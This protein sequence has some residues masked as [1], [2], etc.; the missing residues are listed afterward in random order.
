MPIDRWMDKEDMVHIYNGILLSHKKEWN[1]VICRDIDRPRDC[2]TEWSK[3]E[4]EKQISYIN[5][6]IWKLEKQYR[7]TCLQGR[8]KDTD[9]EKKHM[10]SKGGKGEWD[11][12]GDWDWHIYTSM[13][14][15]DN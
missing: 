4:R 15:I 5:A 2:H 14:K 10:D 8:N 12:L 6:Y 7:W 1:W 11:E 13:Y 9:V 3:S